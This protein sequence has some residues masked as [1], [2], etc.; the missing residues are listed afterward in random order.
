MH[1]P[2]CGKHVT[3]MQGTSS[4]PCKASIGYSSYSRWLSRR[5]KYQ[6]NLKKKRELGKETESLN[7][8]T[9][10]PEK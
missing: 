2:L 6:Q 9:H 7:R 5:T 1:V 10:Q 4:L 8:E 3:M